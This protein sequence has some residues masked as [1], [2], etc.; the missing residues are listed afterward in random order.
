MDWDTEFIMD[1]SG[2]IGRIE[3]VLLMSNLKN[4]FKTNRE[5]LDRIREIVKELNTKRGN[6][7]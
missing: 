4:V 1:Y 6:N 5:A 7:A 3:G 2:A